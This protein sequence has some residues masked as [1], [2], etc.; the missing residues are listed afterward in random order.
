VSFSRVRGQ[1]AAVEVLQAA[2]ESGR[3]AHAYLFTGPVGVGKRT[4]ARELVKA[5]LCEKR[6]KDAC[7]SCR[8]CRAVESGNSWEFSGL[9]VE[10]SKGEFRPVADSDREIKVGSIRAMEKEL[11]VKTAAGRTRAVLLPGADRMNEEAQN[12]LL[13]TLEEPS[14]SS[15]MLLTAS[16][17]QALLPT[18]ISRLARVRLRPLSAEEVSGCL[19]ERE[20]RT[21][22]EAAELAAMANGSIGTALNAD[23]EEA[24]ATRQFA[25]DRLGAI[26]TGAPLALAEEMMEF[27]REHSGSGKGLEPVRRELLS[28][29][30]FAAG[31]YRDQLIGSLGEQ[32]GSIPR[33]RRRLEAVI[34]AEEAIT[35]YANPELVCRVFAGE[36]GTN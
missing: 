18:V 13:K 32:P 25:Q 4:L 16:R 6:G 12:A 20:G 17:P 14:G 27:A 2:L 33:A 3:L 8:S 11:S 21:P 1:S 23:L 31:L 19:V 15:L 34:R 5:V 26:P 28:V 24:R 9:E 22:A 35:A 7:D 36:L 30:H 29:L 10:V